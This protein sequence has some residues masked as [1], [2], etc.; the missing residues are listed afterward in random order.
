MTEYTTPLCKTGEG[1]HREQ[2]PL[3]FFCQLPAAGAIALLVIS[4]RSS[5][6]LPMLLLS[7]PFILLCGVFCAMGWLE[8]QQL[9]GSC[10]ISPDGVTVTRPFAQDQH[11]TWSDFQQVCICKYACGRGNGAHP[12]LCFVCKGEQRSLYD[13]WKTHSP[14]HHRSLIA[15]D[16]DE[17]LHEAVRALCPLT[18]IDLRDTLPYKDYT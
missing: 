3:M 6:P 14:F 13:R 10:R 1:S 4:L 17:A 7:L 8:M 15:I 18:I 2:W 12:Q 9:L 16:Y 11:L 5:H